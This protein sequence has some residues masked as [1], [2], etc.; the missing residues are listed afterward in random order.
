MD[1]LLSSEPYK[2]PGYVVIKLMFLF[3]KHL[4]KGS[5]IL[6][7]KALISRRGGGGGGQLELPQR[8]DSCMS[9]HNIIRFRTGNAFK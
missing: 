3:G 8:I 5:A 1:I 7:I 4:A 6:S 2:V 9:V